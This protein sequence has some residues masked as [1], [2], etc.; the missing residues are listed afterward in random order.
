[1]EFSA[2]KIVKLFENAFATLFENDCYLLKIKVKEECIV[3]RVAKYIEQQLRDEGETELNVDVEYNRHIENPK[4]NIS[5]K[6]YIPDLIIHKRGNNYC[7]LC[8]CE[9]KKR[10]NKYRDKDNEKIKTQMYELKYQYGIVITK[11]CAERIEYTLYHQY[12]EETRQY[13]NNQ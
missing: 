13:P 4:V 10:Y 5:N 1:M 8:C 12:G 2:D 3:A 9:A 6:R 11:M 7:N